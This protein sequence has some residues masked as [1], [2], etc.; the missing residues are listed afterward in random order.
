[1]GEVYLLATCHTYLYISIFIMRNI[2]KILLGGLMALTT[3]MN[4]SAETFVGERSDFRDET[5]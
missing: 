3:T 2:S 5:V 1:M 4:V